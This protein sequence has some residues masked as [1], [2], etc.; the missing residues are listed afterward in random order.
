MENFE[1]P[2]DLLIF[3]IKKNEM[4]IYDISIVTIA[5]Q[6]L[7][8]IKDIDTLHLEVA[9]DFINLASYLVY[10]KS[11]MLLP[12]EKVQLPDVDIVDEKFKL[13]QRLV[14]Y[15]FY[16][17]VTMY[18]DEFEEKASKYLKRDEQLPLNVSRKNIYDAYTLAHNYFP[19]IV[20]KKEKVEIN[21]SR[22]N[23]DFKVIL[24]KVKEI[25]LEKER[26]LFQELISSF[27]NRYEVAASL[28]AMLELVKLRFIQAIQKE[29]FKDIFIQK[30]NKNK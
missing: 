6:F 5:D 2:L 21:I 10:L 1:G 8:S 12:S 23:V 17:D 15:S 19:L 3:L 16:K 22:I 27:Y 26:L 24:S 18:L 28:I 29:P 9:A 11:K 13:T 30:F 20:K 7:E 4:N 14:E 25:V